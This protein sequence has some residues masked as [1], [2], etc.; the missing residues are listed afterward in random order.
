MFNVHS[1]HQVIRYACVNRQMDQMAP[2]NV[3][4][5]EQDQVKCIW[6]YINK[7]VSLC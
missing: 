3:Q 4:E 5:F 6:M 7:F 1:Y 2:I